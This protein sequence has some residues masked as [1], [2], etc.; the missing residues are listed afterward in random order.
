[1][2]IDLVNTVPENS[3]AS[4]TPDV[5]AEPVTAAGFADKAVNTAESER[6][7]IQLVYD[8]ECPACNNYCQ[9]VRIRETVGEL[10]MVNAREDSEIMREIT[11]QGL[12]IDEGMVLKMGGKL[13]FGADA[14]HALALISSRSGIFNRLNFWIFKSPRVSR[15]LYPLLAGGR[16]L[17]LKLMRRSRINNLSKS[18]N[19]YF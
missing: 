19:E 7:E 9:V 12:D 3:T 14:V 8:G 11:D 1:V 18:G 16:G 10:K 6:E 17:L 5:D 13:Y 15:L 4:T 2:I